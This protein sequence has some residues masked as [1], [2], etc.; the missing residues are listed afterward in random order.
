MIEE[1]FRHKGLRKK[2]VELLMELQITDNKVLEAMSTVPR[3]LFFEPAFLE[4]AY[5]NKAFPIAAGQTISQPYTV[6]FQTQLLEIQKGDKVL[7]I[8][9]GSGYQTAVLCEVG[10]KVF[11]IERQRALYLKAKETLDKLGYRAKTFYGDGYLGKPAFAPFDKVIVTCGAPFI[12]QELIKQLKVGGLMVIP[13]GNEIQKM[14]LIVKTD[15]A[16]NYEIQSHG[17]FKF[18]PMLEKKANE[19]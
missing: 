11:S 16:N 18:V 12:P 4:F 19:D 3:H 10:A 17:S 1:S 15:E 7:E 6:A 2:M 5:E 13:V 8:G 9:T 14:Q